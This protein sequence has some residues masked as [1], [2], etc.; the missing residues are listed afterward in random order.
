V[1]AAIRFRQQLADDRVEVF[2]ACPAHAAWVRGELAQRHP[3]LPALEGTPPADAPCPYDELDDAAELI[4]VAVEDG[5]L[6]GTS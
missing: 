1:Q 3:T 5:H 6:M 2:D 4:P